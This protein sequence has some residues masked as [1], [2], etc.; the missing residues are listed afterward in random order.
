MN[1]SRSGSRGTYPERSA[2]WDA[3]GQVRKDGEQAVGQRRAEGQV[4]GD[5]VD[6][7]EEVLV[8]RR[9]ENVCY[10]PELP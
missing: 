4:V 9:A 5:L 3:N 7:E 1:A 2:V 8:R 10:C 6:C